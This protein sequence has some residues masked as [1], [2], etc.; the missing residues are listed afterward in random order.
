MHTPSIW[1]L[2]SIFFAIVSIIKENGDLKSIYIMFRVVFRD[3]FYSDDM[4]LT[5]C[6]SET[7]SV[8][9]NTD[10]LIKFVSV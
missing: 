9:F 7:S 5:V 10:F 1:P 4:S 6:P 3:I 2:F 8:S